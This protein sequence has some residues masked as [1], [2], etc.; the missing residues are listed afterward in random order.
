MSSGG[1]AGEKFFAAERKR[2]VRKKQRSRID[3][4]LTSFFDKKSKKDCVPKTGFRVDAGTKN[5]QG[6]SR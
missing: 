2:P 6:F 3:F 5:D 4:P 1:D